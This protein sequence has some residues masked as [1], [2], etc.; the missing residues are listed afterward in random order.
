LYFG[1]FQARDA[2]Q[3]ISI[4]TVDEIEIN[5]STGISSRQNMFD[6]IPGI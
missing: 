1:S 2:G 6:K 4:S 3:N 5:I